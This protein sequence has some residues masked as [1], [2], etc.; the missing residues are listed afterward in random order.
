MK[1]FGVLLQVLAQGG[2]TMLVV[3]G[4]LIRPRP[5]KIARFRPSASVGAQLNLDHDH[6]GRDDGAQGTA[7][8][9]VIFRRMPIVAWVGMTGNDSLSPRGLICIKRRRPVGAKIS[10]SRRPLQDMTSEQR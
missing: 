10:H 8:A 6:G 2:F 7:N 1:P 4:G 9:T 5:R 3:Q